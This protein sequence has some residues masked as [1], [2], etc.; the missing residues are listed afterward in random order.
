M[1]NMSFARY[2][3]CVFELFLLTIVVSEPG[4]TPGRHS[5]ALSQ[6]PGLES[7]TLCVEFL[8]TLTQSVQLKIGP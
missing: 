3:I 8:V 5:S 4:G 7:W 2:K 1:E 6:R